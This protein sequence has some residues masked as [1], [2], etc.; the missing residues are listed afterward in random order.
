MDFVDGIL[1]GIDRS[2]YMEECL[3]NSEICPYVGQSL[4]EAGLR[5][6]TGALVLAI[7][8]T[9]GTLI[10]GPTGE[11]ILME[12]DLLICMGTSEQLRQLNRLLGPIRPSSLRLPRQK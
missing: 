1:S 11:T 4:R 2:F 7:R 8:R 6:K 10:A 9:D 5:L 12:G 3:L